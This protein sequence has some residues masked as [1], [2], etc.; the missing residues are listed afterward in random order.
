MAMATLGELEV[1]NIDWQVHAAAAR[2]LGNVGRTEEGERALTRAILM[3]QRV[4]ATLSNEPAFQ[5]SLICRMREQVA[6]PASACAKN[7]DLA[8]ISIS[9]ESGARNAILR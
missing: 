4:A 1:P 5:S 3:S 9:G 2:I 7:G 6:M 8:E